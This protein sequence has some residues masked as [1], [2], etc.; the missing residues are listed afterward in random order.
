M[1]K[2]TSFIVGTIF[3]S[4]F[5]TIMS[6]FMGGLAEEYGVDY[7][8]TYTSEMHLRLEELH[9]E[10]DTIKDE[11]KDLTHD[12]SWIDKIGSMFASGWGALKTVWSS[13]DIFNTMAADSL[14][15]AEVGEGANY[16]KNA[17]LTTVIIILFVS[18][19]LG[20]ILKTD[21]T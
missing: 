3:V 17:L 19:G 21:K 12:S 10:S 4:L 11:V 15:A 18:I 16:L 20:I 14:K 9:N 1:P 2:L 8:D 7:D 5:I 13:Y 6:I